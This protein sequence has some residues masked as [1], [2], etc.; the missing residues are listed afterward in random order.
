MNIFPTIVGIS[1]YDHAVTIVEITKRFRKKPELMA[2]SHVDLEPD[3]IK[4]GII[5][6]PTQ[7]IHAIAKALQIA[8]PRPITETKVVLTI[9]ESKVFIHTFSLPQEMKEHEVKTALLYE[10]TGTI[11]V[12]IAELEWD[13]INL[14]SS[15]KTPQGKKD[16][17]FIGVPKEIIYSYSTVLEECGLQ[18]KTI[19]IDAQSILSCMKKKFDAPSIFLNIHPTTGTLSIIDQGGIRLT[20]NLSNIIRTAE[21]PEEKIDRVLEIA[22]KTIDFYKPSK[23]PILY[24]FGES[25]ER[26]NVMQE[27]KEKSRWDIQLADIETL[28]TIDPNRFLPKE[29]KN[30]SKIKTAIYLPAMAAA[31]N[32]LQKEKTINLLLSEKKLAATEKRVRLLINIAAITLI[33]FAS[34]ILISFSTAFGSLFF[35]LNKSIAESHSLRLVLLSKEFQEVRKKIKQ[36]NTEVKLLNRVQEQTRK[37]TPLLAAIQ[38]TERNG[39]F[40]R[41]INYD[42]MNAMVVLRGRAQK[43]EDLLQFQEELKKIPNIVEI[44]SPL[45]NFDEPRNLSFRIEL[46]IK[47]SNETMP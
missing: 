1:I 22:Q 15:T 9:P 4:E 16:I 20:K 42:K 23:P 43:R 19:A 38:K 44:N 30:I 3:V 18:I 14:H 29:E 8:N 31:I 7:L 28:L 17:L 34:T 11:P 26:S 12:P 32:E 46:S 36:F 40:L 2:F 25:F 27:L 10:T 47:Q 35:E 13:K 45:S 6:Q 39:V 37:I 24:A 41:S 33:C 5:K 21:K